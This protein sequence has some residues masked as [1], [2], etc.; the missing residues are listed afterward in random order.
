MLGTVIMVMV[1]TLIGTPVDVQGAIYQLKFR[2]S[3][4]AH[5]TRFVVEMLLWG[6]SVFVGLF[7]YKWLIQPAS[8]PASSSSLWSVPVSPKLFGFLSESAHSFSIPQAG[9]ARWP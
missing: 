6:P 1:A 4:Q 2:K 3:R 8:S 9:P 7:V 5:L